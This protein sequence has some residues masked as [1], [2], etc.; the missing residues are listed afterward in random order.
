MKN[1]WIGHDSDLCGC[2]IQFVA[3]E[4]YMAREDDM[5]EEWTYRFF[6]H[7][8]FVTCKRWSWTL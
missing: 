5:L 1:L 4:S 3:Y 7:A 8:S 6:V 2:C